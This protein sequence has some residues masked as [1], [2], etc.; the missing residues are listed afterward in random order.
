M[1]KKERLQQLKWTYANNEDAISAIHCLEQIL[2]RHQGHLPKKVDLHYT[3]IQVL[4]TILG[5]L[6]LNC[7]IINHGSTITILIDDFKETAKLT[8]LKN[9]LES[10]NDRPEFDQLVLSNILSTVERYENFPITI[11]YQ[12]VNE[13]LAIKSILD[14]LN[15]SYTIDV[16][17][18]VFPV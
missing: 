8:A 3:N 12:K 1:I 7:S 4:S 10:L 5:T 18:F 2:E 13:L 11:H 6:D 15:I 9:N 17:K 16:N 14:Y